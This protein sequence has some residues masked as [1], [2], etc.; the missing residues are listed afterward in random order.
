MTAL[1]GN[2]LD[3]SRLAV[4]VVKPRLLRVYMDEVVHRA[5][6]SVGMGAR[7]LRRAAMHRVKVEVDEVSVL[8]DSGLLERVLANL[9]DNALRHSLRDTPVRITADRAG[10]HVSIAVVDVG[11]GVPAGAEEQLFEPFQRLGDRDNTTGVGLGLS[12]VRG[13]VEA[14]GGTVHAEPTPGGGLTMI[15]DLPP[16]DPEPNDR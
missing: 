7:G 3:S 13:F 8:A 12:V 15:V 14:M 6:V 10:D 5:L 9:I 16:A 4:G 2:L 11:P 1:V